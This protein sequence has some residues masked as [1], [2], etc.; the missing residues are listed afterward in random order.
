V[1]GAFAGIR[2][3]EIRPDAKSKKS[4][5][6]WEDFDW[7]AEVIRV[8]KGTSK[9]KRKRNVPLLPALVEFLRPWHNATGPVMLKGNKKEKLRLGKLIGGWKHNC[10]RDSFASYRTA[11][12]GSEAQTALEMGNSVSM[13]QRSY[14]DAQDK[15]VAD[16]W[17]GIRP[18]GKVI[19]FPG[20]NAQKCPRQDAFAAARL[21]V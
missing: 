2:A 18:D 5:L 3:E 15:S 13:V 4:P 20:K 19:P 14:N 9:V 10:L 8:R 12:T 11:I 21:M 6:L 17:F 1:I 16:A 7:D